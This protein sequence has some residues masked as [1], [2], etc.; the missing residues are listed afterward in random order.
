MLVGKSQQMILVLLPVGSRLHNCVVGKIF[1]IQ[2]DFTFQQPHE[3]IHPTDDIYYFTDNDI[4]G[5]ELTGMCQFVCQDVLFLI[6]FQ[7]R[8]IDENPVPE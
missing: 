6:F 8:Q 5:M 3:R 7:F 1:Q 4:N 2:S